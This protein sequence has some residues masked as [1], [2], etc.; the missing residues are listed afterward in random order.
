MEPMDWLLLLPLAIFSVINVFATIAVVRVPGVS[1]AHRA[2]QLAFI[3][4]VPILGSVV[5]LSSISHRTLGFSTAVSSD[6]SASV[7]HNGASCGSEGASCGDSGGSDGGA[8]GC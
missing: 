2:F 3:W 4:L 8:S 5:C 6:A 1:R 7:G